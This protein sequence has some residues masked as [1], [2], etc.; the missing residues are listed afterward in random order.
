MAGLL[1]D[2]FRQEE[3]SWILQFKKRILIPEFSSG[4]YNEEVMDATQY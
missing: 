1:L 4:F 3:N 2:A